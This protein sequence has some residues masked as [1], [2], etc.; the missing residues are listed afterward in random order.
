MKKVKDLKPGDHI[1]MVVG[2]INHVPHTD[3]KQKIE[4]QNPL[5]SSCFDPGCVCIMDEYDNIKEG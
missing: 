2:Q 3:S 4:L 1:V 5:G